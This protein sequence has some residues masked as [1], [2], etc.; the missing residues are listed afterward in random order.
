MDDSEKSELCAVL[1]VEE[2][3]LNIGTLDL[4]Y[5]DRQLRGGR[6]RRII[7]KRLR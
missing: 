5:L 3:S 6:F 7:G 4:A 1:Q 2:G